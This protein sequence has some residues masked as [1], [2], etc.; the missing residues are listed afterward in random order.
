MPHLATS[1]SPSYHHEDG[2]KQ[3]NN[4]I[5]QK[6]NS[7]IQKDRA[8]EEQRGDKNVDDKV[9]GLLSLANSA[10]VVRRHEVDSTR[11][12]PSENIAPASTSQGKLPNMEQQAASPSPAAAEGRNIENRNAKDSKIITPTPM[13]KNTNEQYEDDKNRRPSSSMPI[14]SKKPY[15]PGSY[16]SHEM[17]RPPC[18]GPLQAGQSTAETLPGNKSPV[19]I[20]NRPNLYIQT[21]RLDEKERRE[22][23]A[24]KVSP[25]AS[26]PSSHFPEDGPQRPSGSPYGREEENMRK[27]PASTEHMHHEHGERGCYPNYDHYHC[28][29]PYYGR[30]P[31]YSP[32][33]RYHPSQKYP[34]YPGMHMHHYSPYPYPPYHR[35]HSSPPRHS[36]AA[37]PDPYY[38]YHHP[39]Y[40]PY[41]HPHYHG[42]PQP[43][44]GANTTPPRPHKRPALPHETPVKDDE[45]KL[46]SPHSARASLPAATPNADEA[47][48]PPSI[49][50][51]RMIS[52][53]I[54][55][56]AMQSSSPDTEFYHRMRDTKPQTPQPTTQT[57][58]PPT[59]ISSVAQWQEAQIMNGGFAPSANRC[60]P[61]KS[62][63][64]SKFWGDVER[65]KDSHVPD[66]HRLVNFP[67]YLPKNRPP[68]GDGMRCC[69]M[70]GKQRICTASISKT[71]STPLKSK[72][73][74]PDKQTTTHI[75]PRQNKGLCTQCD[76]AVWVVQSSGLEIK[77]CK[78]CKNFRP[79][80]AFGDKG[81]ATKCVRCRD[82]QR[83]K[84]ALQKD[85]RKKK[86][87]GVIEMSSSFENEKKEMDAAHGLSNL[88]VAAVR[89]DGTTAV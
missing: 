85:S 33:H 66:F 58:T 62:P 81:L 77:W 1:N 45:S 35:Y 49:K 4:Q 70:C 30:P 11:A 40:P 51:R 68:P 72:L 29:S 23:E 19:T 18:Y 36:S 83:E 32:P 76:V 78:G 6:P 31:Y 64:P 25:T 87:T 73:N 37:S 10:Q 24:P 12:E 9:A 50:K 20:R 71:N 89:S 84:Y 60:I 34:P 57:K 63:V 61:L 41:G 55:S 54:V 22:E 43:P 26:T 88:L 56:N 42:P 2:N 86:R 16:Y 3:I 5:H 39:H 14:Y 52:P 21:D 65:V 69:V 75:I 67:D 74:T 82:R 8:E 15:P 7:P 46:H 80:A 48:T 53:I 59:E 44:H 79:W 28:G 17:Y 27:R 47:T 13:D 38:G